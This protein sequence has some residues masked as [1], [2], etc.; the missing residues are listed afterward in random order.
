[1]KRYELCLDLPDNVKNPYEYLQKKLHNSNVVFCKEIQTIQGMDKYLEMA[2]K[3]KKLNKCEVCGKD[4]ETYPIIL[5]NNPL[6]ITSF[7]EEEKKEDG[8]LRTICKKCRREINGKVQK[9][10]KGEKKRKRQSS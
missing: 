10:K 9:N 3:N 6:S 5:D 2:E 4:Y 8:S 7:L 1:M